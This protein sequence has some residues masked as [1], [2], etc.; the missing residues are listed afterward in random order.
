MPFE[1]RL[2]RP[3]DEDPADWLAPDLALLGEQLGDDAERLSRRYPA[4][5]FSPELAAPLTRRRTD[6]PRRIAVAILLCGLGGSL[7]YLADSSLRRRELTSPAAPIARLE[8]DPPLQVSTS[9]TRSASMEHARGPA[10]SRDFRPQADPMGVF[11]DLSGSEQE[12]VLDL[13]EDGRQRAI[14]LA[15]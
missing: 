3:D 12:A 1:P 2:L 15:I 6:W 4:K 10:L 5:P 11:H 8:T 14:E 13:L 9:M 7:A